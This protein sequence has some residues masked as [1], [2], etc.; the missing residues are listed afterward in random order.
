[1]D[2]YS[3]SEV[4]IDKLYQEA[5]NLCNSLHLIPFSFGSKSNGSS[6]DETDDSAKLVNMFASCS[7]LLKDTISLDF[8]EN[9]NF[10]LHTKW[11]DSLNH[12]VNLI[13]KFSGLLISTI[14]YLLVIIGIIEKNW[15]IKG[16]REMFNLETL[17]YLNILG[18]DL[19]VSKN[20]FV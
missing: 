13:G 1:M 14:C 10:E 11:I 2:G 4:S 5:E 15:P 12:K 19:I 18:G 6:D 16:K 9:L 20:N 17:I 8:N 3:T 7:I